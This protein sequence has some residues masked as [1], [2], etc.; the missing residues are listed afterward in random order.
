MAHRA[1]NIYYPA[2]YRKCL[3]TSAVCK[4]SRLIK[5]KNMSRRKKCAKQQIMQRGGYCNYDHRIH[6]FLKHIGIYKII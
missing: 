3:L 5:I 4:V 2:I 1:G 6:D